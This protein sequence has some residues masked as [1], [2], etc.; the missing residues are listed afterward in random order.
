MSKLLSQ[1]GYGCVYHPALSCSDKT[2][3]N[4]KKV[5][6]LQ[7]KDWYAANEIEIGKLI[8]RISNYHLFFLPIVSS[9][10]INIT[11]IDKELL[12]ECRIIKKNPDA[13]F[14][15]MK[16]DYLENIPFS[17]Y[18]TTSHDSSKFVLLKV[19]QSY[20]SIANELYILN[21]NDIVHHDLK[22]DNILIDAKNGQ[23][24][25][26]DFGISLNMKNLSV[27]DTEKLDNFFYIDAPNYY[28]WSL[29]IHIINYIVQTRSDADYGLITT[30]ELNEIAKV[31][32]KSNAALDSFSSEFR[33]LFLKKCYKYIEQL[34]GKTN[35]EALS[36]LL[37]NY[38]TWDIYAL[39]VI[40]FKIIS[41]ICNNMFPDT[42][43][44][45]EFAQLNLINLS[46]N[47]TERLSYLDSIEYINEMISRENSIDDLKQTLNSI[48]IDKSTITVHVK[49]EQ[50]ALHK[51]INT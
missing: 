38:K 4:K 49:S 45:S 40:Y 34:I 32:V 12:S 5:S 16:M 18:L 6:K 11:N 46:P 36:I 21:D 3:S 48:D 13:D 35:K 26:I 10:G 9:C 8:K 44:M 14:I 20:K 33:S 28:P 39:S 1:G 42:N 25:I 23:P 19:L 37:V 27:D 7:K 24:I 50:E 22:L 15:L 47:P 30:D 29:D 43:F 31:W 17:E 51:I 41:F 2:V